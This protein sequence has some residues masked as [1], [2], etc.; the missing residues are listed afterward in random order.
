MQ[1]DHSPREGEGM[2]MAWRIG[3]RS[4]GAKAVVGRDELGGARRSQVRRAPFIRA[5]VEAEVTRRGFDAQR[6][7]G[8]GG[9]PVLRA[10]RRMERM[11]E[12]QDPEV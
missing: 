7:T 2:S 10:S 9:R 1:V 8:S 6:M 11:A 5:E 4:R 3:K 12:L